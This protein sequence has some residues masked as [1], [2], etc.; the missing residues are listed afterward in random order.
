MGGKAVRGALSAWMTLI[1]LQV[2]GSKGSG[3][4]ASLFSDLDNLVQRA[5][6]PD[7]PAIPDRRKPDGFYDSDGNYHPNLPGYLGGGT[8]PGPGAG[9]SANPDFQIIDPGQDGRPMPTTNGQ[10]N[11]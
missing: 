5:L 6:S 1:V 7:V 11:A 2:V 4:I 3:K 9:D 8:V 10:H